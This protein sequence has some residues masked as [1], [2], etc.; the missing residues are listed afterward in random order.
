MNFQSLVEHYGYFAV[1]AAAMIEGETIYV[2]GAFMAHLGYLKLPLVMSAAAAGAFVGDNLWFWLGRRHGPALMKRFPWMATAVP[3]VD[4]LIARW[5]FGAVILLRFA[6]GLR[7]AGPAVV[8]MGRMPVWQFVLA[9]AIGA[10]LWAGVVG[11]LGWSFGAAAER[12][13]GD[14]KKLEEI[15]IGVVALLLILVPVVR[16]IL[17]RLH[18]QA[19]NSEKPL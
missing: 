10:L 4:A 18:A 14:A 17:R 11:A 1:F 6:V 2:I 16:V 13:L 12:W 3:K 19:T 5:R 15:A 8:G 7:T 9:N